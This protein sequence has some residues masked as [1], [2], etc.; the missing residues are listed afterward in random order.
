MGADRIYPRVYIHVRV[1]VGVTGKNIQIPLL[2]S[3]LGMC[4]F[5]SLIP[6]FGIVEQLPQWEITT[7]Q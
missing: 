3:M 5:P 6:S 2:G 7:S 4:L 1:A